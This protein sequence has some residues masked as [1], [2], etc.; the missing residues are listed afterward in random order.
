MK[1]LIKIF[2]FTLLFSGCTAIT[3]CV[4]NCPCKDKNSEYHYHFEIPDS[5]LIPDSG[6]IRIR[7]YPTIP[8]LYKM[9]WLNVIQVAKEKTDRELKVEMDK[10]TK[11]E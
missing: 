1:N 5:C 4:L 2:L 9:N 8:S 3:V 7:L 11:I 10:L 6:Y